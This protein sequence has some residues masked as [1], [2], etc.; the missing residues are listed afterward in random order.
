MSRATVRLLFLMDTPEDAAALH[1]ALG[2]LHAL[3]QP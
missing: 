2:E 1:Q 3:C